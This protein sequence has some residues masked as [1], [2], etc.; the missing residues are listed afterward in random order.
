VSHFFVRG[1]VYVAV[2]GLMLFLLRQRAAGLFFREG[3]KSFNY[4]LG[5]PW[6]CASE[7][8]G[9]ANGRAHFFSSPVGLISNESHASHWGRAGGHSNW[10]DA[11]SFV[12]ENH[13]RGGWRTSLPIAPLELISR[14]A[15]AGGC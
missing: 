3:D 2:V 14:Q 12:N 4:L 1:G 7:G 5:S 13:P 15:L 9:G 10:A 6:S 11:V 8:G